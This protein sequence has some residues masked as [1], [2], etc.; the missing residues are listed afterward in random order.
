MR[1]SII[2]LCFALCGITVSAFGTDLRRLNK[3]QRNEYLIK[4]AREV[5]KNFGPEWY[6]Q[7]ATIAVVPDSPILYQSY[8][9][10]QEEKKFKGKRYYRVTLYYD[11]D[12]QKRT[13]YDYASFVDIWED[14]GEPSG[15]IFGNSYGRNFFF[16]SYREWL[17]AGVQQ[18]DQTKYEDIDI[19]NIL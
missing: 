18:E 19:D 14:D 12:T 4:L 13:G 17:K 10:P 1:T 5:T 8:R 7:G 3:Q 11:K 6:E 15:I 2:T 9:T 16:F